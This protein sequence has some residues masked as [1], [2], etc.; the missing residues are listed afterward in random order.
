MVEA[1]FPFRTDQC[2]FLTCPGRASPSSKRENSVGHYLPL[3]SLSVRIWCE[4]LTPDFFPPRLQSQWEGCGQKHV[5][6][7]SRICHS[8]PES[9]AVPAVPGTCTVNQHWLPLSKHPQRKD[10]NEPDA[11][12]VSTPGPFFMEKHEV[13]FCL[14]SDLGNA[15]YTMCLSL[16]PTRHVPSL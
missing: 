16:V 10:R 7:Q 15:R 5:L 6:Y 4:C 3:H 9:T 1:C 8:P 11:E 12:C 2:I 13:S 14:F